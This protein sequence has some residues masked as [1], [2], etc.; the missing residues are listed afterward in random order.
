MSQR[1]PLARTSFSFVSQSG[2]FKQGVMHGRGGILHEGEK[3]DVC[4]PGAERHR[5]ITQVQLSPSC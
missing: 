2:L 3:Y 4:A 5:T 1:E